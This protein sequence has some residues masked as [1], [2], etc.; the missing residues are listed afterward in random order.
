MKLFEL[1]TIKNILLV[2]L[3]LVFLNSCNG[4]NEVV[5]NI[6]STDTSEIKTLNAEALLFCKKNNFNTE[7]YFLIDMS[8]HSGKNRFIVI[9]FSHDSIIHK[10]LVTHGCGNNGW[11]GDDTRS[12]PQFSNTCESHCS[13]L[14]KYK[15]ADRGYSQWGIHVKYLLYGL[16]SS[17]SNALK[18]TIVL[19]SWEA[20]TDEE[21]FPDGSAESWGCPA[22]SNN[23]MRTLD[24]LLKASDKPVLLWIIN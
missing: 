12:A 4:N 8:I 23:F 3:Q 15:V 14:G 1:K 18:R 6:S 5:K 10:A 13:S 9:S 2:C 19:H 21:I 17:N 24:E 20:V 22:V 11:S 16:D 7:F